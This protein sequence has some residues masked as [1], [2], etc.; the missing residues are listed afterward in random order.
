MLATSKTVQQLCSFLGMVNYYRD[1]W[2]RR[3]HILA[4]L[5]KLT[6]KNEKYIWGPE[7]QR[8]FEEAKRAVSADVM[9]RFPDFGK[10]F[11]VH[12]DA[13]DTQLGSVISQ[14]GK[15]IAFYSRKLT[16]TQQR[17]TTGSISLQIIAFELLVIVIGLDINLNSIKNMV[18]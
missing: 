18:I 2:R 6:R 10:P 9:L 1:M 7:Q 13:S 8:A 14:E 4:P 5:T 17:Y 15:P 3:S 11:D 16:S 12:T